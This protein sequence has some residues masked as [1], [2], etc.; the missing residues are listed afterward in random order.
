MFASNTVIA[1]QRSNPF[2]IERHHP[3]AQMQDTKGEY[4]PPYMPPATVTAGLL[5]MGWLLPPPKMSR[6]ESE[7]LGTRHV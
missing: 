7:P 2:E 1:P 6:K 3:P 4:L 5:G